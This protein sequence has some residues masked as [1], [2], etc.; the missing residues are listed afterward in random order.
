MPKI[1]FLR[2]LFTDYLSAEFVDDEI[3]E[4]QEPVIPRLIGSILPGTKIHTANISVLTMTMHLYA[5]V[6]SYRE[7][8]ATEEVEIYL[9]HGSKE[10]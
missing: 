8:E 6:E 3:I 7:G 1:S 5:T 4:V 9:N 10:N 2:D